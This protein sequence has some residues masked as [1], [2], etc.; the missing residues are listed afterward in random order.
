MSVAIG[1]GLLF[2]TLVTLFVI[3]ALYS[4][5]NDATAQLGH[6]AGRLRLNP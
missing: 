3:P 4:V 1:W 2:S 5:A 6:L